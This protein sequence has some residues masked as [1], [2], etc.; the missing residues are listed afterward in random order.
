MIGSGVFCNIANHAFLVWR[1]VGCVRSFSGLALS[2]YARRSTCKMY[3][4]G[5]PNLHF[6]HPSSYCNS[7]A[8]QKRG[9]VTVICRLWSSNIAHHVS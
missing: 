3:V 2:D 7:Y 9:L 4:T 1:Y 6:H 8:S 5:I